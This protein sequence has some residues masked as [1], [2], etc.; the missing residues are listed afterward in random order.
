MLDIKSRREESCHTHMM[1]APVTRCIAPSVQRGGRRDTRH[2]RTLLELHEILIQAV[3]CSVLQSK[4]CN[5]LQHEMLIQIFL[6][7]CMNPAEQHTHCTTQHLTATHFAVRE[8]IL[9]P[10]LRLVILCISESS[11]CKLSVATWITRI[12]TCIY[13]CISTHIRSRSICVFVYI[14][15]TCIHL[16]M[17]VCE[18]IYM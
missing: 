18:Y 10:T 7:S 8:R 17:C 15:N 16:H 4:F 11:R 14:C 2:A 12:Y 5:T 3:C 13:V 9:V 1:R 6:E